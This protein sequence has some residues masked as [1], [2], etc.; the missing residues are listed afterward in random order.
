MTY[1]SSV[2]EFAADTHAMKL[3]PLQKKVLRKIGHFPRHTPIRDLHTAF[4]IPYLYDY[5]RK[6]CRQQAEVTQNHHNDNVR[7]IGQD[8][9]R[10]RKYKRLKLDGGQP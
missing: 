5:I 10:H 4:K 9:A 7:N 3:Q 2:C 8:E 6:L 1:A